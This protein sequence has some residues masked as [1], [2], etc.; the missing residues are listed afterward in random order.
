MPFIDG[1]SLRGKLAREKRLDQG[2]RVV[3]PYHLGTKGS[4]SLKLA[5]DRGVRVVETRIRSAR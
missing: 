1:E 5:V 3:E 4:G 2:V